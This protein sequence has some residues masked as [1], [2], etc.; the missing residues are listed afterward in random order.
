MIN[1]ITTRKEFKDDI[2][3]IC[4]GRV[5]YT[6]RNWWIRL[7]SDLFFKANENIE[8]GKLLENLYRND[9]SEKIILKY[10]NGLVITSI[11][12][13]DLLETIIKNYNEVYTDECDST[14]KDLYLLFNP[15]TSPY[16]DCVGNKVRKMIRK[17]NGW[18]MHSDERKALY[19]NLCNYL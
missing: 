15:Y 19:T 8:E 10:C 3:K 18:F 2:I 9:I 6:G 13:D 14:L 12:Y 5:I 11:C 17:H 7:N 1:R 4:K 16:Y